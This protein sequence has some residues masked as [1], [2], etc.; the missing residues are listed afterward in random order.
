MP[1]V[2]DYIGILPSAARTTLQTPPDFVNEAHRGV[3]VVVDV[4]VYTAGSLTVTIQGKDKVS[5]KYFTLLASA[6]L[7]ATGTVVLT[8]Y[9][10][11]TAA[12]NLTASDVLPETWRV[13]TAV[14]DATSIT[15]SIGA[16]LLV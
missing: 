11:L 7:A 10:G 5:R 8:V 15:Y 9:P 6:A 16:S 3:K 4:T 2:V 1:K 12:G 13:V 14:G